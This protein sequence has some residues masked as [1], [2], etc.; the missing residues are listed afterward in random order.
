[1][2]HEF[3]KRQFPQWLLRVASGSEIHVNLFSLVSVYP[4]GKLSVPPPSVSFVSPHYISLS[5]LYTTRKV[6][7]FRIFA[8]LR[9]NRS[10]R[11]PLK[12]PPGYVL[13]TCFSQPLLPEHGA[14]AGRMKWRAFLKVSCILF[15]QHINIV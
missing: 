7:L 6:V 8:S 13:R 15:N 4:F 9:S 12:I 11:S 5:L 14:G 10:T 3:P 1:M 2:Y